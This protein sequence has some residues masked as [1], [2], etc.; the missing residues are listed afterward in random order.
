MGEELAEVIYFHINI[1]NE[2]ER[3][4]QFSSPMRGAVSHPDWLDEDARRA[5]LQEQAPLDGSG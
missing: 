1:A 3:L 2:L 5:Y 4:R